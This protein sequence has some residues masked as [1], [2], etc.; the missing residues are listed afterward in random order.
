MVIEARPETFNDISPKAIV[1][2]AQRL[3][4]INDATLHVAN[5]FNNHLTAIN[6]ILQGMLGSETLSPDDLHEAIRI[7]R[8]AAVVVG[9]L[10]R[11]VRPPPPRLTR[12]DPATV[13]MHALDAIRPDLGPAV[14]IQTTFAEDRGF[15]YAD[16]AQIRDAIVHLLTNASAAIPADGTIQIRVDSAHA[17]ADQLP[18]EL[19]RSD[20][21][22]IEIEDNGQGIPREFLPR[23]YEPFFSTR[24]RPGLGLASVYQTVKQHHGGITV[25]SK[26]GAGT[27]FRLYLPAHTSHSVS[28]GRRDS[29]N[30]D[31][32]NGPT[33]VLVIDD[34][35]AVRRVV[36]QCLERQGMTVDEA[37]CG[38]D[39]LDRHHERETGYDL[40]VLDIIMP[41]MSGWDV[42][43]HLRR[44]HDTTPVV[45]QSGFMTE[46][47]HEAARHASAFLR[48]PYDL[49][50]LVS[51]VQG[52]LTNRD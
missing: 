5:A 14:T 1:D 17:P 25:D 51:A 2:P 36:R 23:L 39:G 6:G 8:Q 50:D 28:G 20:F 3:D 41:G 42:L 30:P 4:V 27:T 29:P 26:V 18:V 46:V 22:V 33:S 10:Q 12:L 43:H 35:T 31:L 45:L 40:I 13:V 15:L 24:E 44:A 21:V 37:T 19:G 52:A 7:T 9:D 32:S 47:D 38:E 11:T 34:D 16:V 48:K 49:V